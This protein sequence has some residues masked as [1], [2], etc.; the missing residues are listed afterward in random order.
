MDFIFLDEN[1]FKYLS[2]GQC[3][4]DCECNG[5]LYTPYEDCCEELLINLDV[6][7]DC[8]GEGWSCAPLGD[9]NKDYEV[10]INDIIMMIDHILQVNFLQ[11]NAF[12]NA[13]MNSDENVSIA[14]VLLVVKIIF[15]IDQP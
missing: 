5:I 13:D 14:D 11:E 9:V 2:S 10:N 3:R 6:C 15:E 12:D 7:G 4:Q 8:N 1:G